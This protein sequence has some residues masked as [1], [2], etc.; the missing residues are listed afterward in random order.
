MAAR[1]IRNFEIKEMIGRGGMASLYKAVQTSLDRV[2]AIKELY[3][4]LAQDQEFIKRFEREAKSAAGLKHENIIDVIDFGADGDSFFIAMEFV[5][6]LT[7]K[8]LMTEAKVVP[9]SITVT[10][11]C[12]FLKGLDHAHNKSIV[13]R[14]IKPANIMIN[15]EGVVKI[16]DFGLAQSGNLPTMTV[17]GALIGTPAYMSPEQAAGRKIDQRSDIF[18]TGVMFYEM[19]T[20]VKPFGGEN[21]SSIITKILTE[22]PPPIQNF[23]TNLQP[24]I[25]AILLRAL[26]KDVDRRYMTAGDMLKDLLHYAEKEKLLVTRKDIARFV[27]A[28]AEFGKEFREKKIKEHLERGKYF[29]DLGVGKIDDAI[30]QYSHV[31]VLDPQNEEARKHLEKLK[32][33]K[34][35]RDASQVRPPAVQP[36]PAQTQAAPQAQPSVIIQPEK[37]GHLVPIL[38]GVIAALVILVAGGLVAFNQFFKKGQPEAP[39]TQVAAV[40]APPAAPAPA[41]P[42]PSAPAQAIPA[43]A[44]P[45]APVPAP[46]EPVKPVPAAAPQP[47]VAT[48]IPSAAV[49][50]AA[51]APEEAGFGYLKINSSPSTKVIVDGREQGTT[52]LA[53]PIRLSAGNHKV[54]LK[55]PDFLETTIEVPVV[56]DQT[57]EKNATLSPLPKAYFKVNAI[58]WADVYIDGQKVATTPVATPIPVKSGRHEIKLIN[59][60]C[61]EW[62]ETINFPP[63]ETVTKEYRLMLK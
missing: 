25:E 52:P 37:R 19:L 63:S 56:K 53:Q 21:Y 24:E 2:V 31:I 54:V 50:P 49:K 62:I 29:L 59:P 36:Q 20:G 9:L 6:G 27:A 35:E 10:V 40:P 57:V 13:H 45:P 44:A 34:R 15:R 23:V 28:P 42:A 61:E 55:N 16:A 18:S 22:T 41:V 7:L 4:H 12:E 48:K 30:D 47:K 3:P 17:T 14:D 32:V 39:P 38:V 43:P 51:R 26:E 33:M 11:I 58:P 1:I 8:D 60:G 46:D 5:D